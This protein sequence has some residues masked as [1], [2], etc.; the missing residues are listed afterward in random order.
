MKTNNTS[1]TTSVITT[2]SAI[3]LS[4]MLPFSSAYAETKIRFAHHISTDSEQ[5]LA[6]ERFRDLAAKYSDGDI[7]VEIYPSGQMGGQR[8]II[9]SVELGVLEMGYGES[10]L[11]AN[12]VPEFGLL[13]LPYLYR[14]VDHWENVVTGDI[15]LGLINKLV[16]TSGVRPLNWILAGYRD[17]Y[18]AKRK[19]ETPDN[20]RNL[21]IRVPESPVFVG[22][23][24]ALSAQPT[25]VPMP[26]VYTALQTGVVDAMEGTPEVGYTFRIFE[27]AESLSK[28]RHI[29][30][31]GSFAI[32]DAFYN[33]LSDKNREA[34]TRAAKEA[35]QM[36]RSEWAEREQAW[37]DKLAE[38]GITINEVDAAPFQ[39]ALAQFRQRF[40]TNI[41]STD[42]LESIEQQ[43]L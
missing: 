26:E 22:T 20:F 39:D 29:L 34:V 15:G 2:L 7:K 17:T 3:G 40:A 41:G 13:T 23:F 9:E 25:P 35:A 14:D 11:Y 12:Y 43:G 32:N 19:I 30:F 28:T 6:A 1:R 8:E 21:K 37:F 5:H 33:R 27:V 10:G 38:E 42:L 18:L 31:D 36:Q 4:I 24:S 16:D